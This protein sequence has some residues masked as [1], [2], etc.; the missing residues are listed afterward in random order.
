MPPRP[1]VA[2]QFIDGATPARERVQRV[3]LNGCR[4]RV[5]RAGLVSGVLARL[6]R[7]AFGGFDDLHGGE[8]LERDRATQLERA[9][10][11]PMPGRDRKSTRL[12]SSHQ[13]TS[14]AAFCLKKK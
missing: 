4:D 8:A 2:G 3:N 14:Y 11:R 6:I 13:I 7:E 10:L 12:N 9:E 1:I 5:G